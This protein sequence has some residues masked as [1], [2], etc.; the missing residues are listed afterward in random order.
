MRGERFRGDSPTTSYKEPATLRAAAWCVFWISAATRSI[1][2]RSA[3]DVLDPSP[4]IPP[5][6]AAISSQAATRS[7]DATWRLSSVMNARRS[8]ITVL[9]RP[10]STE[11][12][13][14][15]SHPS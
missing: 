8:C 2:S 3:A 6:A 10:K 13:R 1:T 15:P 9:A 11:S 12:G 4:R 7:R 14:F 5:E